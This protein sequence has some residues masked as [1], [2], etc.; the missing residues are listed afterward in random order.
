MVLSTLLPLYAK[1]ALPQNDSTKSPSVGTYVFEIYNN[2]TYAGT[3][4]Y[5]PSVQTANIYVT[6]NDQTSSIFLQGGWSV[7]LYRDQNQGGPSVCLNRSDGDLADNTFEDGSLLNDAASSFSLYNQAFCGGS[8]VP[9][10]PLEVYNDANYNGA[11]CYAP[12]TQTANIYVT[13]DNQ[14]S[15]VLLR[16]GWSVRLYRDQNQSG[17]SM[18]L[19][20]SDN[21]LSNNTYYDNSSA[22]DSI[23]SFVL[24]NQTPCPNIPPNVPN[25]TA[26]GN[27][28]SG[29]SRTITLSWQDTGDSDNAPRT[30]RDFY[31]EVWK[32]DNSWSD[33]R[34][35]DVATNWTLTVPS[36]GTYYW[37]VRSGD[38][39]A[40]SEWSG[41]WTFSV[42]PPPPGSLTGRI[43]SNG[44]GVVGATVSIGQ[45]VAQANSNGDYIFYNIPPNAV[46]SVTVTKNGCLSHQSNVSINSGSNTKN[47]IL[48]CS[49]EPQ[50][51]SF[52]LSQ[53]LNNG[54]GGPVNSYYDLDNRGNWIYDF[55]HPQGSTVTF[56]NTR[57]TAP[58]PAYLWRLG[59]A[60]NGH[61][62]TDYHGLNNQT[63]VIASAPG[64]VESY[65]EVD[66]DNNRSKP[67][68]T[69]KL[70]HPSIKVNGHDVC[71]I[72]HHLKQYT[73]T[74]VVKDAQRNRSL[75]PRG[76]VLAKVGNSG[77]SSGTHL[78]F[79]VLDCVTGAAID[80]YT[81]SLWQSGQ[82]L[83]K[84]SSHTHADGSVAHD[85][86]GDMPTFVSTNDVPTAV[87][88]ATPN[89][90][91]PQQPVTLDAQAS[92]DPDGTI[93][94]YLWDFGDGSIEQGATIVH[95]YQS[96]GTYPVFLRTVDDAG[97]EA[98]SASMIIVVT[99][100]TASSD[101]AAPDANLTV[102]N[103]GY[104]K[105]SNIIL[106]LAL[107]TNDTPTSVQ[108]RYSINGDVYSAWEPFQS[109]KELMLGTIDGD[110]SIFVQLTDN[111]GNI[112]QPLVATAVKDAIAP[113]ITLSSPIINTAV[114]GLVGFGWDVTDSTQFVHGIVKVEYMLEGFDSNWRLASDSSYM[115]ALATYTGLVDGTYVFHVRATDLAGNQTE[116][117]VTAT[118]L[119]PRGFTFLPLVQK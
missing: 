18:C 46:Y 93:V 81:A 9:A 98:L 84:T 15:A 22:N 33:F 75:L 64:Y 44:V 86:S 60:Y 47:V 92:T 23:S 101:V 102:A 96:T 78:H 71:T 4:C 95:S 21:D 89:V 20:S 51:L 116:E 80:P 117:Q 90:V 103:N 36:D 41:N 69:V 76:T 61:N 3:W 115:D 83:K 63:N 108:A 52:P 104:T 106:N 8:P 50:R 10:Y 70:R 12:N 39:A 85:H 30:Y 56:G 25:P 16:S 31:V 24:F 65:R 79:G 38:G 1:A 94:Q 40:G 28:S 109:S 57:Y 119:V 45:R 82:G 48:Q 53:R 118:V 19:T 62:G 42:N 43:T 55:A 49:G 27:G 32:A 2:T 67:G 14:V 34:G 35:W 112:S 111:V 113:A 5:A 11:W 87:F 58:W 73:V 100:D 110:Y 99:T 37:R 107:T 77:N 88:I 97:D 7:R 13:C 72:Y 105:T 26:P 6:C 66:P 68:N 29:T 114:P 74:N 91:Q 59:F 17:P 54:T